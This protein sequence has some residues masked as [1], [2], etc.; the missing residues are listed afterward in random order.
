M[1]SRPKGLAFFRSLMSFV[2]P[3]PYEVGT[4]LSHH[5]NPS[6]IFRQ[7]MPKLFLIEPLTAVISKSKTICIHLNEKQSVIGQTLLTG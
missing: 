5:D 4:P 1:D 6:G 2:I 7:Q 3:T